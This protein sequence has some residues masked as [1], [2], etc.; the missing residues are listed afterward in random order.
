MRKLFLPGFLGLS[1]L[2]LA[3]L[4]TAQACVANGRPFFP[5]Q[6]AEAALGD[7]RK[8]PKVALSRDGKDL[9]ASIQIVAN[10]SPHALWTAYQIGADNVV[11][12]RYCLIQ[13][14]DRFVRSIKTVTIEWRLK[15]FAVLPSPLLTYRIEG[16]SMTA[17]SQ[18]LKGLIPQLRLLMPEEPSLDLDAVQPP[19][20][21]SGPTSGRI[22][23]LKGPSQSGS[24]RHDLHVRGF[25]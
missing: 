20:D 6:P 5:P 10:N 14:P 22:W 23:S 24:G 11:T 16:F 8:Q 15:N 13:N 12:L 7:Q 4:G 25:R 17:N 21:S 19:D 18:E 9:V 2:L 3:A 1:I